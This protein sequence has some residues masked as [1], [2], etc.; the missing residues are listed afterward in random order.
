MFCLSVWSKTLK[1]FMP[2]L[3]IQIYSILKAHDPYMTADK[4]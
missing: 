3:Y 2:T 4:S 1:D